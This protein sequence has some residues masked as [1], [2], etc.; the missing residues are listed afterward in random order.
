MV[1]LDQHLD[2]REYEVHMTGSLMR[3]AEGQ[4]ALYNH[5]FNH[6]YKYGLLSTSSIVP[7]IESDS[8]FFIGLDVGQYIYDIEEAPP[9]P[10]IGSEVK[11]VS[12]KSNLDDFQGRVG[13]TQDYNLT[14]RVQRV[15]GSGAVI[16][17]D[18]TG[19]FTFGNPD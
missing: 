3:E 14:M 16:L 2:E 11:V 17:S 10:D 1:T 5:A 4:E 12:T 18:R 7:S 8:T 13:T 6:D 15:K 19:R 9:A